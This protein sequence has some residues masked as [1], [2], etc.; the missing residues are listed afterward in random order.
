MLASPTKSQ[1]VGVGLFWGHNIRNSCLAK[2]IAMRFG[3]TLLLVWLWEWVRSPLGCF[4]PEGRIRPEWNTGDV[5]RGWGPV[6]TRGSGP[7]RREARYA[8]PT[9]VSY[10]LSKRSK[11]TGIQPASSKWTCLRGAH[12]SQIWSVGRQV[13]F[14]SL[15]KLCIARWTGTFCSLLQQRVGDI[16]HFHVAV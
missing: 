9:C 4:W 7:W 12:G 14:S 11:E 1:V 13:V 16:D 2:F 15:T 8:G 3:G 10:W 5:S 6:C